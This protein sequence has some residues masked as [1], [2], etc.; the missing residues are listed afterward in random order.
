[1]SDLPQIVSLSGGKDSTAMLLMMLE[2]GEEV[3][4]AVSFD[5]GWEFPEM[6][7]HLEKLHEFCAQ[8]HGFDRF[9]VLYPD[10]PLDWYM[11][12]KVRVR[13]KHEGEAGWGWARPR[14]RWCTKLKTDTMDRHVRESYPQGVVQCVGIAAD[15][16]RRVR[17]KRYP[18]VEWGVTE[19][20]ALAYCRA[21]GFDWGGLYEHMDR[22]SCWCCPLQGFKSLRALY[23]F[24]PELWQRLLEMDAKC[25][26]TFRRDYSAEQID[27][28][29]RNEDAQMRLEEL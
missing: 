22:V 17:D 24:H 16:Q 4:E 5:T 12:D 7:E 23:D 29:F 3:A 13:G 26:N 1:M 18:L 6:Y 15:E 2:R 14:A 8:V 28:R 20:D 9:T 11:T 27:A 19:A 10:R 25:W 21:N